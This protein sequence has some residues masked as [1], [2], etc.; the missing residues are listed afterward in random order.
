MNTFHLLF[1]HSISVALGQQAN[2]TPLLRKSSLAG[3]EG[4]HSL[5]SESQQLIF[6]VFILKLN[7]FGA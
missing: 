4:G 2:P 7:G 6:L 5:F 1:P 3:I